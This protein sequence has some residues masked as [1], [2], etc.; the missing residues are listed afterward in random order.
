MNKEIENVDIC[1]LCGEGKEEITC[2][3]CGQ[4]VCPECTRDVDAGVEMPD[5]VCV[6]CSDE[7]W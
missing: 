7:V 4:V 5:P 2:Y 6:E 1:V 3:S